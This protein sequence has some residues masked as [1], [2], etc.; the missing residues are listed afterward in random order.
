MNMVYLTSTL[1]STDFYSL[2]GPSRL[3]LKVS[4]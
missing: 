2:L 3:H 4:I 1:T